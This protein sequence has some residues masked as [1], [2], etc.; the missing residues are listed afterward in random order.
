MCTNLLA[1]IKSPG[2]RHVGLRS[3]ASAE[4][5]CCA[6]TA[7]LSCRNKGVGPGACLVCW[8][9]PVRAFAATSPEER[10]PHP[11]ARSRRG[12]RGGASTTCAR[13]FLELGAFPRAGFF[14]AE[15]LI[16]NLMG[17][18]NHAAM[19]DSGSKLPH[20]RGPSDCE[21]ANLPKLSRGGTVAT[22]GTL[23]TAQNAWGRMGLQGT[24]PS[25]GPAN[26]VNSVRGST[27]FRRFLG[28]CP[29]SGIEPRHADFSV[30][31]DLLQ[32]PTEPN[33]GGGNGDLHQGGMAA[34]Q[35]GPVA[36]AG[37][38]AAATR[39]PGRMAGPARRVL[40]ARKGAPL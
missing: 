36:S 23:P 35:T 33:L 22:P 21:A 5:M 15:R 3:A 39:G 6:A 31:L 10:W 34:W 30:R 2:A 17:H 29:G 13:T 7:G 37:A 11:C 28:R 32:Y 12:P 18:T 14:P 16:A 20:R 19:V 24:P 9:I 38:R 4:P 40:R 25:L 26:I 8:T 1:K 27:M